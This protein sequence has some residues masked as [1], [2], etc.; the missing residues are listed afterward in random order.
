MLIVPLLCWLLELTA[1]I[2]DF[3][4]VARDPALTLCILHLGGFE[5]ARGPL[6]TDLL[7]RVRLS[8][9]SFLASHGARK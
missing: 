3:A 6:C 4:P 5:T 7:C 2:W 9:R 1:I 8:S